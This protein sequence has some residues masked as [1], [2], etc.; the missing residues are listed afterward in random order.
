M[1]HSLIEKIEILIAAILLLALA[2]WL[3]RF[4][5]DITLAPLQEWLYK[6]YG[7]PR[8]VKTGQEGLIGKIAIVRTSFQKDL[9][10]N[11]YRGK[12]FADGALWDA[13]LKMEDEITLN[14]GDK[15]NIRKIDGLT[16]D[17][18]PLHSS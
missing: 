17:I 13:V 5:T 18:E 6:R 4:L 15:V 7:F 16:L 1:N 8:N 11:L 12:V 3:A 10:S 2:L 14:L 9:Q